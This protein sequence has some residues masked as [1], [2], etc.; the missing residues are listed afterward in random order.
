M[1]SALSAANMTNMTASPSVGTEWP[2]SVELGIIITFILLYV[3]VFLIG[4]VIY[5]YST[6]IR[7]KRISGAASRV[8]QAE[9]AARGDCQAEPG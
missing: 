3:V 9:A 4:P 2:A 7:R 1:T 8:W 5:W 6:L